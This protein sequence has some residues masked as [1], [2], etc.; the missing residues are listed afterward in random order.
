MNVIRKIIQGSGRCYVRSSI[1][2]AMLLILLVGCGRES[3][4][5]EPPGQDP[6]PSAPPTPAVAIPE[7]PPPDPRKAPRPPEPPLLGDGSYTGTVSSRPP[8]T[9]SFTISEG[10]ITEAS[11][12]INGISFS[13]SGQVSGHKLS[14]GGKVEDDFLRLMGKGAE[15]N[16]TGSWMGSFSGQRL[17]GS[18]AAS[19]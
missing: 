6:E 4:P 9:L 8:G 13:L 7:T 1:V 12:S 10:K 19:P 11:A 18:W 16:I 17:Q 14:L 3:P 15:E 5:S 2:P